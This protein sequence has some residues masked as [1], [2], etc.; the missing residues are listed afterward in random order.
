[1]KQI[2][3]QTFQLVK[4]CFVLTCIKHYELNREASN[5]AMHGQGEEVDVPK[6]MLNWIFV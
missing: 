2:C 1:M 3:G 4:K 5:I 6:V